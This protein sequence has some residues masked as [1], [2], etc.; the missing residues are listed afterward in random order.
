MSDVPLYSG[1]PRSYSEPSL[2]VDDH[3]NRW[4]RD[5]RDLA[6]GAR[7]HKALRVVKRRGS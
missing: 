5:G 2:P 1:E 4:P 6:A 3:G 7:L